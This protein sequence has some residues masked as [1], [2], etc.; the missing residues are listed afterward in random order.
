MRLN[1][2]S[3]YYNVYIANNV[4]MVEK[5][6]KDHQVKRLNF[7]RNVSEERLYNNVNYFY[8]TCNPMAPS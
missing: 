7:L 6:H 8:V 2:G 3:E 5:M 4:S 1:I